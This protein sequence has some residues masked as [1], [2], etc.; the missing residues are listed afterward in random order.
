[1]KKKDC[2]NVKKID[3]FKK[4]DETPLFIECDCPSS[5]C[6]YRCPYCFLPK[7]LGGYFSAEKEF[8]LWKKTL[9]ALLRKVKRPMIL[10]I[11]PYG[12][13]LVQRKWKKVFRYV[14]KKSNVRMVT[15]VTNLSLPIRLLLKGINPEKV[16]IAA[17]LHPTQFKD[18]T[19]DFDFFLEQAIFLK[20]VGVKFIINYVFIPYQLP[21]FLEY[22]KIFNEHGITVTG[23]LFRGTWNGK[24]YPDSYTDE[25]LEMIK[26]FLK[27]TPF[28]FDYQ[29]HSLVPRGNKCT[30]GRFALNVNYDGKV[31]PC[32]YLPETLGSVFDK[33]LYINDCS[34]I[35]SSNIC[36]CKWTIPLQE[37]IAK[38]YRCVGNVH[39]IRKRDGLSDDSVHPF[40]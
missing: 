38:K 18:G 19:E 14:V 31:F 21:D 15:F 28:I 16:G 1:M 17:T 24:N 29:T 9:L 4:E 22:R 7:N 10:S 3:I 8:K 40:L 35:C 32:Y 39:D 11:G 2:S 26:V 37:E 12:E 25:E 13:P 27:E 36:E 33:E 30:A 5:I 20:E 23:N 6:N 34:I